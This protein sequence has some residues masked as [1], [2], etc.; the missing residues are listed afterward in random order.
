M[1]TIFIGLIAGLM[2]SAHAHAAASSPTF[3]VKCEDGEGMRSWVYDGQSLRDSG[4]ALRK[5]EIITGY[6]YEHRTTP[7]GDQS[8]FKFRTHTPGKTEEPM[9]LTFNIWH[10]ADGT[11]FMSLLAAELAS[12]GFLGGAEEERF[13]GCSIIK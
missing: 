5:E 11:K 10:R 13:D 1:K 2:M 12:D 6:R 8:L 4:Y 9:F 3:E 7:Y